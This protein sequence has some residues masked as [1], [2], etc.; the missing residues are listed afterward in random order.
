LEKNEKLLYLEETYSSTEKI[1][2]YRLDLKPAR[3]VSPM[4]ELAKEPFVTPTS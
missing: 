4:I 2:Y 3:L 1:Y